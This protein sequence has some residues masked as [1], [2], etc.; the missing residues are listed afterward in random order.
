MSRA[1]EPNVQDHT[2]VPQEEISAMVMLVNSMTDTTEPVMKK[3][4]KDQQEEEECLK[5]RN[6]ITNGWPETYKS[7]PERAKP[8][9]T[10]KEEIVENEEGFLMKG[11]QII[12]PASL[13]QEMLQRIHE[14]H[15]GIQMSRQRAR[16]SVYWPNMYQE[17]ERIVQTCSTYQK[18]RNAQSKETL[19]C[20]EIA[21]KP[22]EKVGADLFHLLRTTT[23]SS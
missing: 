22:F 14:G 7:K 9:W 12:I 17:L 19:I 8:Y 16:D 10:F 20:H 3:I 6:M 11:A 13:R 4:L 23:C 15:L 21:E 18:Y 1:V 5:S 2:E